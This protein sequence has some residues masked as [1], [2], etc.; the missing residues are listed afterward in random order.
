MQRP[1]GR[2]PAIQKPTDTESGGAAEAFEGGEKFGEGDA[3]TFGIADGGLAFRA[4]SGNGKGHGDA[5][6]AV[7]ID[8]CA[9][10]FA[11]GA[12]FDAHAIGKFFNAGAHGAQS[13]GERGD[14]VAFLHA[15][16]PCVVNFDSL[17][18]ERTKRGEHG[19][20][21]DHFGDLRAEDFSAGEGSVIHGYVAD[22]FAGARNQVGNMDFRSEGNEEIE[23]AAARGI[24][25]DVVKHQ[26]RSGQDQRGSHQ[27]NTA[28][29]IAGND[30]L[31]RGELGAR[32]N[33]N[34]AARTFNIGAK[35]AESK[36]GV[37]AGA[38]GFVDRG[39]AVGEEAGKK[40][41]GLDLCAGS[42][43]RVIDGVEIA[44]ANFERGAAA[45]VATNIGAHLTK[46]VDDA[47]HGAATKRVVSGD[48]GAERLASEH[49]GEHADGRAGIFGVE[50]FARLFQTG[51]ARAG[52]VDSA[53]FGV[54]YD[55]EAAETFEGAA[56]VGGGGV[57]GDFAASFGE[58]G[59]DG[60]TMRDGFIAG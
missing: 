29:K 19:K 45:I 21:V 49:T 58:R 43:R 11:G 54:N 2:A 15:Q 27:E 5:M 40:N 41:G 28:G 23:D 13:G 3:D 36:L 17:L 57:V 56:A 9:A 7:G 51:E 34:R 30:E 26:R 46:R 38:D 16:L 44:A 1:F 12:A 31:A 25:A 37:V 6:I 18:R 39:D 59:D 60:V 24:Q 33:A 8:S 14:A 42:G 55:A 20:L 32:M 53:V 4:E 22:E 35:F 48:N 10:E 47:A 52:D 50:R